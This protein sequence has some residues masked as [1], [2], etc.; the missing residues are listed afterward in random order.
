MNV[1]GLYDMDEF[2]QSQLILAVF[3]LEYDLDIFN[4]VVVP[5]YDMGAM[6]NKSLNVQTASDA[7]YTDIL[8]VIGHEYFYNWIGNRVTCRDWFQLSLKEGLTVFRAQIEMGDEFLK[9]RMEPCKE[10]S[11]V[12]R[13]TLRRIK[14]ALC[15]DNNASLIAV[16]SAK[17]LGEWPGLCKIDSEGKARKVVGC[18]CVVVKEYVEESE[19]LNIVQEYVKTH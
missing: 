13:E 10:E 17:T 1:T 2:V 14:R 15:S 9:R 11:E 7:D 16:P 18:S 12:S 6:E 3:G 8:G 19:G 5:D 4:I